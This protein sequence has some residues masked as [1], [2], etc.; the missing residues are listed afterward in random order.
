MHN[1]ASYAINFNSE[2]ID[3]GWLKWITTDL[4]YQKIGTMLYDITKLLEFI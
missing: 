4:E 1:L 2:Q 3:F